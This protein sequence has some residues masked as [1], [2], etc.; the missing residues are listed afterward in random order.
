[1]RLWSKQV[2][3]GIFEATREISFCAMFRNKLRYMTEEQRNVRFNNVG[4]PARGA[5]FRSTYEHGTDSPY[6]LFAVASFEKMFSMMDAALADGRQWLVGGD[7]TLGDIN[8]MPF[9]AR[10][11]YLGL[12]DLFIAQR[13]GVQAWWARSKELASY[14]K[15]IPDMLDDEDLSTMKVSGG[16]IREQIRTRRDEHLAQYK[17][18]ARVA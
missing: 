16:K 15:A 3:E 2:D 17:L 13:P 10:L 12:L 6:V 18:A 11:E 7:R 14:R 4:D 5:R 9:V 8:P 1:M